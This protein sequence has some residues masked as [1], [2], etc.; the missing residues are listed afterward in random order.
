MIRR[1]PRSTLFP[2]TTL[3]R[4]LDDIDFLSRDSQHFGEQLRVRGFQPLPHRLRAGERRDRAIGADPDVDRLGRK[5]TGPFQVDRQPP[6]PQ[7][8][9]AAR[10]LAPR[11]ETLPV[12]QLDKPVDDA[13]SIA[14]VVDL[15][16]VR[17]IREILRPDEISPP[18]LYGVEPHLARGF[19]HQP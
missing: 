8:P 19:L 9:A 17:A 5:G 16:E 12:G 7:P 14:A 4:S 13:R 15:A 1:P 6:A 11:R 18:D 3:F 10:L 2:Y